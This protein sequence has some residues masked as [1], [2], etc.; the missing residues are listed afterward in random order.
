MLYFKLKI[1]GDR[2]VA[3]SFAISQVD[4]RVLYSSSNIKIVFLIRRRCS[5]A[6]SITVELESCDTVVFSILPLVNEL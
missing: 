3:I 4:V 1:K 5:F 2:P 6:I